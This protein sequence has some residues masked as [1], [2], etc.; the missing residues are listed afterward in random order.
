MAL[1]YGMCPNMVG[2]MLNVTYVTY[3]HNPPNAGGRIDT[4]LGT[5][6]VHKHHVEELWQNALALAE[7]AK[8]VIHISY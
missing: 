2:H 8:Q 6:E 1:E 4:Q 5:L 3:A 7:Q